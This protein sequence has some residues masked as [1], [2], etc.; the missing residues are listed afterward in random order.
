MRA[1]VWGALLLAL[2]GCGGGDTRPNVLWI[3]WDTVRADHL[4]LYGYERK[5]TPF[6]DEWAREGLVFEDCLSP[7]SS[8]VPSHGS[9]FTGLLPSEHGANFATKFLD[10]R[11]ETVAERLSGAGYRTYLFAANPNIQAVENFHQG[12]DVEEHPWDPD[13]RERALKILA[14]KVAGRDKATGLQSQ[15]RSGQIA[16]HELRAA[17]ALAREGLLRFLSQ[18]DADR[19]FFA[20]LNYM[21]AHAPLVSQ[22]A[23]RRRFLDPEQVEESYEQDRSW[24]NKWSYTYGFREL[25]EEYFE[26]YR[27]TYDAALAELDDLLREL[28]RSLAAAGQLE[29]T[30]VVVT[31]DHGEHLGEHH[32]VDH[33]H[34]LYQGLIRVPLVLRGPGIEPGRSSVPVSTIDLYRTLL[35]RCGVD[36]TGVPDS[37]D[38]LAPPPERV[39]FSEYPDD[40]P[41]P[42]KDV[43]FMEDGTD[44]SAWRRSLRSVVSGEAKLIVGSDGARELYDL[45]GDPLETTDLSAADAETLRQLQELLDGRLETLR[46][47]RPERTGA[48][49]PTSLRE[50]LEALGYTSESEDP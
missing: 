26:V 43:F 17:G 35:T 8:T 31:S 7:G 25:P 11:F 38:L 32:L 18:T 14:E 46:S 30:I 45:E 50:Q 23:Y 40:F 41:V 19:P 29:N 24:A 36:V 28:F 22:E 1:T 6:L 33:R 12:F 27:G 9:M 37:Y 3:V 39:R 49:V 47:F 4:S 48:L 10:D 2:P 13:H 16:D 20:F 34:S 21:E 44:L 42:T 15:I 5:T